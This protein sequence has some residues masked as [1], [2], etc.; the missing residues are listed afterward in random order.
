MSTA[1][2]WWVRLA[3]WS[4]DSSR[5]WKLRWLKRPVSESVWARCSRRAR[6]CALSIASAA[7][8]ANRF[9]SSN[10][11]SLNVTSTPER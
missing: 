11:V 10:S 7:A 4:A 9:A 2:V 5:S 3:S 1:T 8:S 6:I